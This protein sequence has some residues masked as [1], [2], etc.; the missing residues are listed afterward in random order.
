MIRVSAVSSFYGG[1]EETTWPPVSVHLETD[2]ASCVDFFLSW[3]IDPTE[4]WCDVDVYLIL[5]F[6]SANNGHE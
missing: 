4:W 6:C 5:F 3:L 1:R 2:D